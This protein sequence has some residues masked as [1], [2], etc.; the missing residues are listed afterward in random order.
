[1][2]ESPPDAHHENTRHENT[3]HDAA[4]GP[5]GASAPGAPAPGDLTLPEALLM[6]ALGDEEGRI[7]VEKTSALPFGLTASVLLTLAAHDR[8]RHAGDLW[9]V[10]DDT[11]TGDPALD[12]ALQ[13]MAADD[14]PR[15]TMHWLRALTEAGEGE[16]LKHRLLHHLTGEG[17]LKEEEHQFLGIYTYHRYPTED[18]DPER[19]VRKRVREVVLEGKEPG[20]RILAIIA[21]MDACNLTD[22]VFTAK[23]RDEH[24]ARLDDL[25]ERERVARALATLDEE[26]TAA[27]LTAT[28]AATTAATSTL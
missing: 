16:D 14:E 15:G 21:L 27:V 28:S 5:P 1:M 11:P 9:H 12:P 26:T 6:L 19:R 7:H 10:I 24:A 22:E 2:P 17:I 25:T 23:E 18:P 8:L 13:A 4:G 3:R 20:D